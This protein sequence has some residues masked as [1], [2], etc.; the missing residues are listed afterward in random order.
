MRISGRLQG[1][2][3][4]SRSCAGPPNL[5]GQSGHVR[6]LLIAPIPGAHADFVFTALRLPTIVD[7]RER[8]VCTR[9]RQLDDVLGVGE[10]CLRAVLPIDPVPVV[11][12]I[13]G[14]RRKPRVRAHLATEGVN[15]GERGFPRMAGAAGDF[16]NVED[17]LAELHA[18]ASAS[19]VRPQTDALRVDLPEA[20]RARS[21][22]HAIRMSE[23]SILRREVPGHDAIGYP[24]AP[25]EGSVAPLPCV[26]KDEAGGVPS[27][28]PT[29]GEPRAGEN[30]PGHFGKGGA[31]QTSDRSNQLAR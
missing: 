14:L 10:D 22:A 31:P 13:D 15:G 30:P 21:R 23:R 18:D 5:G 9:R 1:A 7:H 29:P 25:L 6:E 8:P 28:S 19:H 26:A 20:E 24:A 27:G 17:A 4:D 16:A 3:P 2:D 12:T 11:A